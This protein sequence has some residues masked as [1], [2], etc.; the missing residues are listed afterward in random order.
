MCWLIKMGSH[1]RIIQ[2]TFSSVSP[3]THVSCVPFCLYHTHYELSYGVRY[4]NLIWKV[5]VVRQIEPFVPNR[6]WFTLMRYQTATFC[7]SSRTFEYQKFICF[8]CGLFLFRRFVWGHAESQNTWC[9]KGT[10]YVT[11]WTNGLESFVEVDSVDSLI[12]R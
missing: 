6:F 12:V 4:R 7:R 10:C 1:R 2:E 11:V 5:T 3:S 8:V 9:Y